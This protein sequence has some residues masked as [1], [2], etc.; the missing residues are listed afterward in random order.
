MIAFNSDRDGDMA[1]YAMNADGSDARRLA[2][3]HPGG[4]CSYPAWSPDGRRIAYPIIM[5]AG[6][7]HGPVEIWVTAVDGSE[8][9][10]VTDLI[11]DEMLGFP[12]PIPDWSPDGTKIAFYAARRTADGEMESTIYIVA[13]P[14]GTDADSSGV[15]QAIPVP[16]IASNLLWSPQGDQLLFT[17]GGLDGSSVY[18]VPVEGAPIAEVYAGVWSADWSPDGTE[19]IVAPDQGEEVIIL[20]LDGTQSSIGLPEGV[21]P[22]FVDWSPNGAYIAV[23]SFPQFRRKI[24][25]LHIIA[26]ETGERVKLI[27]EKGDI[28]RPNWSPDGARLLFTAADTNRPGPWPYATLWSYDTTS[29]YVQRL[30]RGDVH[31]GLG[32]WS[33]HADPSPGQAGDN[34]VTPPPGT[35]LSFEKSPQGFDPWPTFQVVLADVDG[36]GDLDAVFANMGPHHSQVWLNDGS[37]GF[38]DSGQRLTEQGH[39]AGLGDL[40][41]D[42]DLDLFI[43]CAGYTEGHVEHHK[44]SKVYLNDGAGVFHD[45]GQ[46]LGDTELSGTSV[47]LVDIDT[48]GDLD[49]CVR[50]YEHPYKVYLNDGHGTFTESG[51]T[52]SS[53]AVLAWG[54][55]DGDGDVDVFVKERGQGYQVMLNDGTGNLADHWRWENTSVTW[56]GVALGD[57]DGDGDLDAMVA[58]GDHDNSS[59]TVVLFNDGTGRFA[60]SDQQLS[61]TTWG[62]IGLEDLD[63]DGDLDAFI[64]NFQQPDEVWLN[65]GQGVFRNSGLSLGGDNP[66][67]G[68]AFGDL[69][70]DGDIDVFV[71]SFGDVPNVIWI[72]EE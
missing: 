17:G 60:G 35:L 19:I 26:V 16:Y 22:A 24:V 21:S 2:G 67:R 11:S 63:G 12:Y 9:L 32:A 6:D 23:G 52:F 10:C 36:D 40:D 68:C 30:T 3:P 47:D 69:D 7:S 45:S 49:A 42:G 55:L 14:D 50:Y 29:G 57:L 31:D 62:E 27:E 28:Y 46:D 54:D 39:G 38:I 13:V 25:A 66:S 37:G 44:P 64:T 56:G 70:G 5:N 41:G 48:D 15:E 43:S 18:V 72:Q 34:T 1:V 8:P 61:T 33:P 58:N 20:G 51:P 59:P 4:F 71:A 65:D 53:E